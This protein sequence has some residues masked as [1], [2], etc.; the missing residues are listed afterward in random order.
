MALTTQAELLEAA[1]KYKGN[2]AIDS[3]LSL[4]DYHHGCNKASIMHL[5]VVQ[6]MLDEVQEGKRQYNL[7]TCAALS[8]HSRDIEINTRGVLT[9]FTVLASVLPS[10]GEEVSY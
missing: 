4:I 1:K 6:L 5:K 8:K 3:L 7:D 2:H 10:L 9:C